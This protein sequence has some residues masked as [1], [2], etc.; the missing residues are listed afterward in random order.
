[1]VSKSD[2][3]VARQHE[4][5]VSRQQAAEFLGL[6]A[7]T[8]AVWAMKGIHLPVVKVGARAVR[9]RVSDLE[10]FIEVQTVPASSS[11]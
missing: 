11:R 2:A 6:S 1:M 8:L 9:Y 3:V 10:K 5:L 7:Q 4:R